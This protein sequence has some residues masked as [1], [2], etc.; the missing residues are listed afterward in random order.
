MSPAISGFKES[1]YEGL[2]IWVLLTLMYNQDM[3]SRFDS[4]VE[5]SPNRSPSAIKT[6][7]RYEPRQIPVPASEQV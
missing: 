3:R 5:V 7:G 6:A 4:L 2:L 1:L